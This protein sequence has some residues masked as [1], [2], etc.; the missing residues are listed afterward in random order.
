MS[1]EATPSAGGSPKS[2]LK[3]NDKKKEFVMCG[4]L[5]RALDAFDHALQKMFYKI[6]FF[7]A[8]RFWVCVGVSSLVAVGLIV[9]FLFTIDPIEDSRNLWFPQNSRSSQEEDRY[10][11]IWGTQQVRFNQFFISDGSR[12]NIFN[13]QDFTSARAVYDYLYTTSFGGVTYEQIC[14]RGTDDNVCL[15]DS[16]FSAFPA[17]EATPTTL[18]ALQDAVTDSTRTLPSGA[19]VSTRLKN[20]LGNLE[21]DADGKPT[22]CQGYVVTFLT[23]AS[24]DKAK[25]VSKKWEEAI[26]IELVDGKGQEVDGMRVDVLTES[27]FDAEVNESVT[28]DIALIAV[29]ITLVMLLCVAVNYK[30]GQPIQSTVGV[31]FAGLAAVGLAVGAGFGFSSVCGIRWVVLNGLAPF[32]LI[33]VGVDDM[34]IILGEYKRIPRDEDPYHRAALAVSRAGPSIAMTTLTSATAFFV[35]MTSVF[36]AVV[37]FCGFLAISILMIFFYQITFFVSFLALDAKRQKNGRYDYPRCCKVDPNAPVDEAPILQEGQ[38]KKECV[39]IEVAIRD[40][41]APLVGKC[42][43]QI[44][45]LVGAAVFWGFGGWGVSKLR[46]GLDIRNLLPRGSY[47]DPAILMRREV[48]G[49][50]AFRLAVQ[51][52][53]G[54]AP[55]SEYDWN[56]KAFRMEMEELVV[57]FEN[58]K[59][60]SPPDQGPKTD[61]WFREFDIYCNAI[62]SCKASA[63]SG[64]WVARAND[65]LFRGPGERY[66]EDVIL[67]TDN[68]I[69]AAKFTVFSL[70]TSDFIE[71]GEMM[72]GLRQIG[73]DSRFT[74][75]LI[76]YSPAFFTFEQ[77]AVIREQ[78]ATSLGF[79]AAA[80]LLVTFLFLGD[81]VTVLFVLLMIILVDLMLFGYMSWWNVT[82]DSISFINMVMAVGFAVDYSAHLAHCFAVHAHSGTRSQ[83]AV[84]SMQTVGVPIFYGG[85][86]TLLATIPLAFA[87]SYIF[88][89]FFRLLFMTVCFGLVHGLVILPVLLALMGPPAPKI[90]HD[91]VKQ[92][93]DRDPE[94]GNEAHTHMQ[95]QGSKHFSA[96]V[97]PEE[98][99]PAEE[100]LKRGESK[101]LHEDANEIHKRNST[102]GH[103]HAE[104]GAVPV[105]TLHAITQEGGEG[106]DGVPRRRSLGESGAEGP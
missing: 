65:W 23:D 58:S 19:G 37:H 10:E 7:C 96:E 63:E 85:F 8:R 73:D 62:D 59:W 94:K 12:G 16:I 39:D 88:F 11:V 14:F 53:L 54:K 49:D 52:S 99:T 34:F 48:F 33:G 70:S 57:A 105:P 77:S 1:R 97:V 95:Q 64:N 24:S 72:S 61:V 44:A 6:A 103:Q 75:E 46:E 92:I 25:D 81:V 35:G 21:V 22:S 80:V 84:Y 5:R 2:D 45:V 30:Y 20:Y 90:R 40:K 38:K 82:L 67:A 18:T 69:M 76:V 93:G 66:N 106:G 13:V 101:G 71:Q 50:T 56:D 26:A 47:M 98:A 9:G 83:R 4:G 102:E 3:E 42:W 68:Q 27:S 79:A 104:E 31:S 60:S 43:W 100:V 15:P 86:S 78:T 87:A 36:P 89:T 28:G 32:L 41:Y 74:N 51:I 91:T 17:D 29:A 55:F